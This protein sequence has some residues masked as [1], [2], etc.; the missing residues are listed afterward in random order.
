[1][2]FCFSKIC[3]HIIIIESDKDKEKVRKRQRDQRDETARHAYSKTK[4]MKNNQLNNN[5]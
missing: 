4:R 2:H 5:R 1:M 3:L